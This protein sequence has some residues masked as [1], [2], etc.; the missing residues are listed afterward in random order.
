MENIVR[1]GET[2]CNKQIFL[3]SQCVL[4]TIS[5]YFSFRIYFK[6]SGNYSQN[7]GN[8]LEITSGIVMVLVYYTSPKCVLSVF[9]V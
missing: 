7:N 9:K 6:M 1:K 2:A 3:L 8:E 5:T 4:L